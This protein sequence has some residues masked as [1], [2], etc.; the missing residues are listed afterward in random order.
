MDA[1]KTIASQYANSATVVQMVDN[2]SQTINPQIDFANFISWIWNIDTAQGFG[3]DILG[4]I[5]GLNRQ[6]TNVPPI[7]G[8]PVAPGG[9]YSMT[10]AQYRQALITKSLRNISNGSAKDINA[11]LLLLSNG[12]GNAFVQQTG[13]MVIKYTFFYAPQPYEYALMLSA[14][15]VGKPVGVGL[16]LDFTVNPYFGFSEANSWD[17]FGRAVFASY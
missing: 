2:L 6:V 9:L 8:F 5:L 12:R 7:F 16:D 4:R 17:T 14:A 11:E 3:L 1:Y 15:V 13:N 10:D